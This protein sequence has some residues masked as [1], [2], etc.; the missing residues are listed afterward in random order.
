MVAANAQPL[1]LHLVVVIP[2]LN[3][4]ES[5]A[6]VIRE[7]PRSL[8][9][10]G[11]IEVI[12]VDDGSTDSTRERAM[13]E[14]ASVVRHLSNRGLAASFNDGA[15]A[16]LQAGADIVVTLDGDGQHDP[17]A[18]P[19][20][21]GPILSGEADLVIASRPLHNASQGTLTRRVGNRMGTAFFRR[22]LSSPL[23]DVTSGYRALSRDALTHLHAVSRFT[24]TL[25]ILLQ[26]SAKRMRIEEVTVPAR[27]RLHGTSRMTYSI[28]RY[29]A[30]VANQALRTAY[31]LDP[32]RVLGRA[33]AYLAGAAIVAT[34]WFVISYAHGGLHLSS[35]LASIILWL[36]ALG[37][38][39]GGLIADGINANRRLLEE[40]LYRQKRE[41]SLQ[42]Q[43]ARNGASPP[44]VR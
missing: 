42:G 27:E 41:S 44:E 32:M 1:G 5:V 35:L 34:G 19:S 9:G 8:E 21:I 25:D 12:V 14:G 17:A 38:F 39:V 20:L 6:S 4:E 24:Y 11:S 22:M 40:I 15:S 10:I 23:R 16:A 33:S 3:E 43:A 28:S 36:M 31:H 13:A 2:A 30:R 7:I 37:L 29:V 18:I 26:A